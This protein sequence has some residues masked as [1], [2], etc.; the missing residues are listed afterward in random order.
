MS[1]LGIFLPFGILLIPGK[2]N[3]N[4]PADSDFFFGFVLKL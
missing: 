1:G 3:L 4:T 2:V